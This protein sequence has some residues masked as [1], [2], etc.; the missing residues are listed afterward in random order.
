[1]PSVGVF[2]ELLKE[3]CVPILFERVI[4]DDFEDFFSEVIVCGIVVVSKLGTNHTSLA[5]FFKNTELFRDQ[6]AGISFA[7]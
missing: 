6:L 5:Y 4:L 3:T 7:V 2:V 1:M